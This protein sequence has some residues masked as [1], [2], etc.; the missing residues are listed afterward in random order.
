MFGSISMQ[1]ESDP[2]P[3]HYT[4]MYTF[5]YFIQLQPDAIWGESWRIGTYTSFHST[6][7]SIS[8]SRLTISMSLPT[9]LQVMGPTT[10]TCLQ[11][12]AS[13]IKTR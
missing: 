7:Q 2:F 5:D 8:M 1:K 12:S 10:I 6:P 11:M 3:W 13:M 4:I 9:G